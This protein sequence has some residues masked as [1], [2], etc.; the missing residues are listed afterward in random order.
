MDSTAQTAPRYSEIINQTAVTG[1][2]WVGQHN[3]SLGT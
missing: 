1:D 2:G 3:Q